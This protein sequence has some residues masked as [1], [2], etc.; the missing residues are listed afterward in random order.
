MASRTS[1]IEQW[2]VED[3]NSDFVRILSAELCGGLP[4][5]ITDLEDSQ[6]AITCD[7]SLSPWNVL[8]AF[9]SVVGS[10]CLFRSRE[11]L[12]CF[13]CPA[14]GV[15]GKRDLRDILPVIGVSGENKI[16]STVRRVVLEG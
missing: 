1:R 9:Y 14:E 6:T 5:S 2:F 3:R 10:V 7:D 12:L 4:L 11:S 16:V 15:K 13:G 8:R